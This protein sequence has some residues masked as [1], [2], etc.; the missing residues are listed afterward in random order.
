MA[1]TYSTSLKLELIGN[2]DQSGTWGT[3]TNTNLGTLL[4]QAIT[5]VQ[6]I[7]MA[8]AN[9]TLTSLNGT[10]DQ[11]RNAV[12]VVGGTNSAIRSI[13]AP[14]VNKIYVIRNNTAGGFAI[15][16]KTSSSTGV[17]IANGTTAF[18]YCDGTE[19][20]LAVPSYASTNTPNT[21]VYRDGTGSFAAATITANEL[22]AGS[23]GITGNTILGDAAGD[24][25]VVNA[26]PTFNAPVT[27]GSTLGVTG[28]ATLTAAPVL[29]ALTASSAV[30]TDASKALVS[31]TNTG[32][33]N[34]VLATSP[35]LV[36]PLLGTPTSGTLTNCT[37]LPL[38]TG[39]T[40]T[41]AVSNGGTGV[42]SSTGT[43]NTVL[44]TSPTLVTPLLGTPTSGTLTNCT[45][46]PVTTGVSGLGSDVATFL[47]TPSSANLAAALTDETGTGSAVF[48]TS[49]T[50][51]TPDLG[52]PTSGTLTNCTGLPVTTGVSGLGANVATFLATPSS[53]NLAAALTDETGTGSAV[54][55][56]SPTLV[57]PALG[58]PSALVG[59]NISGTAANLTAG[60]AVYAPLISGTAVTTTS[61]TTADFTGIPS[62]VKRVTLMISNISFASSGNYPIIKLGTS[63]GIT[64]SGY[65]GAAMFCNTGG[66]AGVQ[67]ST[68]FAIYDNATSTTDKLHGT[69]TF[70]LV[71]SN[72]WTMS[73]IVTNSTVIQTS[74]MG[75]SV[76]LPGV[77]DRVQVSGSGGAPFDSGIINILYE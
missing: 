63:A 64:T 20:Y 34:N 54:F 4:E 26:T 60:I 47:A 58:T 24:T 30:A 48:A 3:T 28:V 52:T 6:T 23:L 40:G 7:T 18:V 51:V 1:S 13:I 76:T 22:L 75:G 53:A 56:T 57:T 68:S 50:L 74:W 9:V 55:A 8:N 2:G 66:I 5:G 29:N 33:G 41:L 38:S 42:T 49:P 19:F 67:N 77:L 35:T 70:T 17:S 15:I 69:V 16:I 27:M 32:T 46:L 36:T 45:G 44:S 43:G 11:A 25:L 14:A 72:I 31:V 61:G 59:T 39:I 65:L 71:N 73:G 62:W 10:S 37:G 12:L 21:L